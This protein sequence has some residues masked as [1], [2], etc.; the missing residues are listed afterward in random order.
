M[1]KGVCHTYHCLDTICVEL[2]LMVCLQACVVV[3]L[4][5]RWY[6][7]IAPKREDRGGG[8]RDDDIPDVEA[9]MAEFVRM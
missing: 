5:G 4:L 3:M 9:D 6:S 7:R 1:L 8:S 2:F